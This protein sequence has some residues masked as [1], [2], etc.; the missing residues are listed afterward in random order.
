[1]LFNTRLPTEKAHG[2]QVAKMCEA[3]ADC[4][5]SVEL[6]LPAIPNIIKEDIF[7]YYGLKNNFKVAQKRCLNLGKIF[8]DG[9]VYRV[10]YLTFLIN[11]LFCRKRKEDVYFTRHPEI[12]FV[13]SRLGYRVIF[14]LHNWIEKK[15]KINSILL[16]RAFFAVATTGAIKKE[17]ESIGIDGSKII[18]VPHGVEIRN[19]NLPISREEAKEKIGL[20]KDKKIILYVGHIK[21]SKGV[22]TIIDAAKK[23]FLDGNRNYG[24]IF[25]G[26]L[27]QSMA[28]LK[29]EAQSISDI[30]I[31][32]QKKPN[33]IPL[34]LKAADALVIANSG[35]DKVESFYTAPLKLF[36]Y[37]ASGSPIIA[38]DVP[39]IREFIGEK[40]AVFFE[41]DNVCD[42]KRAIE[43]TLQNS[44]GAA[45]MAE[46]AFEKVKNFSWKN[47]AQIII[48]KIIE[49]KNVMNRI[50]IIK[51]IVEKIKAKTYLEIGVEYGT[52][53]YQIKA[54]RK[55]AVD[56]EFKISWKRKLV[57]LPNRL[58]VKYFQLTS[59]D[60]FSK[61]GNLF[62]KDKIDLAFVDG[63]H[64]YRQTAKDIENCLKYLSEKGIIIVHDCSP[65]SEAAAASKREGAENLP[66]WKGSWCGDVWKAIVYFRSSKN[67]LNIFTLDCDYGLGIISKGR[68]DNML[69]FS[70]EEI[71][72]MNY[73]DLSQSRKEFLNLKSPEY[74]NEFLK[75][76]NH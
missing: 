41:A 8:P 25:I 60:F 61:Y 32:G 64:T 13:L 65:P 23:I 67:D 7:R 37:M 18:A 1:V 46:S 54:K 43:E 27:P 52:V 68:P 14:E 31:L 62:K 38:S 50:D 20:P 69:N 4:G 36:E 17:L 76:W 42:L 56:P 74:I 30:I 71:D 9:F 6:W 3:F 26:G 57:D 33:E 70:L 48:G 44:V 51:K 16:A 21:K 34:F 10:R 59:D 2:L 53:F 55:I 12:V 22:Y 40:E 47:R 49:R 72:K 19:F 73:Y 39:A 29:Q 58:R 63:L 11:L 24:F 35:K 66:G 5:R 15:R 75:L 28:Q 45:R